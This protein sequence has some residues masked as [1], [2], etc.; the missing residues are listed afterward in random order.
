MLGLAQAGDPV[1]DPAVRPAAQDAAAAYAELSMLESSRAG[2]P[3]FD[4]AFGLAALDTGHLTRAIFALERVLAVRPEDQRARAELGRAYLVAGESDSARTE[5]ERVRRSDIPQDAAAAIDRVLGLL[6]QLAPSNRPTFVGYAEI[7]AGHD[8]NVNSATNAGQFAIPSFGGLIFTVAPGSGRT[9]DE[10]G[11]AAAGASV[12]IPFAPGWSSFGG[13]DGRSVL[14]ATAHD[15]NTSVATA[16]LGINH[17]HGAHA[18]TAALQTNAAWISSS[19]YRTANGASMQWQSQLDAASQA[20]VFAQWSRL[21][22]SGAYERDADRSVLGV[23]YARQIGSGGPLTYVSIYGADER[24]RDGE[25][26]NHG[27]RATGWRLGGEQKLGANAVLFAEAQ[28]E[29]RK[30]GGSE[31]LFDI[32]R[33]D[34]QID[35]LAGVRYALDSR[36]QLLPQIRHTAAASNVVL[37]DYGRTVIQLS[38]RRDFK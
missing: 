6:D 9:S 30:Y 22:Y 16:S 15:M 1:R 24:A 12:Q 20:S 23:A 7:G 14:N 34:R 2:D 19:L 29:R 35:L 13:I 27:H 17:V 21:T 37:Y 33:I 5:L 38:V 28:Y 36:W 8:S 11:T 18:Q 4:Y 26:A 10:F 25:F 3:E 31:P 32:R